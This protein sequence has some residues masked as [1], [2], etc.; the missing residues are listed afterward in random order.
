MKKLFAIAAVVA[1]ALTSCVKNEVI[2][3]DNEISFKAVNY[4]NTKAEAYG[5][6][7]STTYPT[8]E[9]F[10]VYA[11]HSANGF[12]N[13]YM[14]NI[15]VQK[16]GTENYWRHATDTY[17]WPKDATLK[18]AC[19]SP[20]EFG[21][22]TVS[23][24]ADKGVYFTGFSTTNDLTQQVDLMT[25]AVSAEYSTGSVPVPFKHLLSQIKFTVR[26]DKEYGPYDKVES[27]RINSVKFT[28]K[29]KANYNQ[30]G[31]A[32]WTDR[33]ADM[34]Y[35]ALAAEY[36][37]TKDG[38]VQTLGIPVM[39][40]PQDAVEITVNYTINYD[41]VNIVT[42]DHKFTPAVDWAKNT[43]YI[44]NLTIGLDEIK[45]EPTV[46]TWEG[47]AVQEDFILE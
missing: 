44:Y 33:T 46:E 47:V 24:D 3:P 45:F 15:E 43:V 2:T 31:T 34:E 30:A 6:I 22:G 5:P 27:F 39:I 32:L 37:I 21:A 25:S 40:I 17:Y 4:K 23:A 14:D 26:T 19:Y 18:F 1:V 9:H 42:T 12:A 35:N 38:S 20:Y 10:G 13:T 41:N 16:Y 28:V 7:A 8:N 29:S 36:Y 11:F